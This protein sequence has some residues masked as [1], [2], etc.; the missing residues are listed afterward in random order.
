MSLKVTSI[1]NGV[2]GLFLSND[3]FNTTRISFNFY[4]PLERETVANNAL[5]PFVLTTCS[6]KYPDFSKLNYTLSK[7]YGARLESSCEK[8]GDFQLLRLFVPRF[9]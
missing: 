3:R 8:T 4:L 9:G 1:S 7:L 2:D 5:L 6:E